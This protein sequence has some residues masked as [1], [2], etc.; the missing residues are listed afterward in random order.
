MT[1]FQNALQ[2]VK[3]KMIQTDSRKLIQVFLKFMSNAAAHLC[4]SMY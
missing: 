1:S 3:E 4:L 2:V